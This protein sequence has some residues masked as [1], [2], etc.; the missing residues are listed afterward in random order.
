M[1]SKIRRLVVWLPRILGL[2]VGLFIGTFALD[3]FSANRPVI[4]GLGDFATHLIPAVG[5]LAVV[6]VSWRHP[7]VGAA[8]FLGL[9]AFYAVWVDRMDWV[10]VISTPLFVVGLLFLASGFLS[11]GRPSHPA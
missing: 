6:A 3:A 4:E 10:L 2:A 9:A 11:T 1:S 8:A 5:I 7:W